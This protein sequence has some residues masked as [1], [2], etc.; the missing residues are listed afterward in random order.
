MQWFRNYVSNCRSLI[1]HTYS[2]NFGL[3][4]YNAYTNSLYR[5]PSFMEVYVRGH[6]GP[7]PANPDVLCNEAARE[8][9]VNKFV[10]TN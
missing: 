9:M 8:K 6:H 3:G 10:F 7:D 2:L 5:F 1:V 4:R